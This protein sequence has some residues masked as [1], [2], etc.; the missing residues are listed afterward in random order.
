MVQAQKAASAVFNLR[1]G[2]TFL[3]GCLSGGLVIGA[4]FVVTNLGTG[5]NPSD[6]S[7]GNQDRNNTSNMESVEET[8]SGSISDQSIASMNLT[9]LIGLNPIAR[10]SKL[11]VFMSDANEGDFDDLLAQSEDLQPLELGAEFQNIIVG[12][13]AIVNPERAIQAVNGLE[14]EYLRK[15][16]LIKSIFNVWGVSDLDQAIQYAKKQDSSF[17]G[18]AAEGIITARDEL[19]VNERHDIALQ[20][21]GEESLDWTL[22]AIDLRRPIDNPEKTWNE[23]LEENRHKIGQ[24]DVFNTGYLGRVAHAIAGEIG[25]EAAMSKIDSALPDG[26]TKSSVYRWFFHSLSAEEPYQALEL[27][28]GLNDARNSSAITGLLAQNVAA[29]DPEGAVRIVSTIKA[30]GL[31]NTAIRRIINTWIESDP[32]GV[33]ANLE[34]LPENQRTKARV[35]ALVAIAADSTDAATRMLPDV[36]H[37]ESKVMVAESIFSNLAKN[38]MEAA[39]TW[40][41][42]DPNVAP[43]KTELMP[44]VIADLA[45]KDPQY[46]MQ[47]AHSVAIEESEVGLE[48]QVIKSVA[49]T[50][51]DKA[52][53]MLPDIRNEKT[54]A[55]A[56][57]E[58][59]TILVRDGDAERAIEIGGQITDEKERTRYFA[60]LIPDMIVEAPTVFID[61]LESFPT[62]RET[63]LRVRAMM[64]LPIFSN[65]FS[66]EQQDKIRERFPTPI[67]EGL[68]GLFDQI[69]IPARLFDGLRG[70]TSD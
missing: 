56:L 38:D 3:V 57:A 20:L 14:S 58:I 7:T 22:G 50:N 18:F 69:Q 64:V 8:K 15:A 5:G 30:S 63:A 19:S 52:I 34:L 33:M 16:E 12:Q 32:Y 11:R 31:R 44:S 36:N 61:N 54:M 49:E 27:A 10:M 65:E 35:D 6:R 24:L 21:V 41:L 9:D 2:L 40:L 25:L 23:F 26:S 55:S 48:A 43:I 51:V 28:I 39:V 4:V 42:S 13:F 46:A 60:T 59:G 29:V 37:Y 45:T 70:R 66:A 53:A 17:R 62:N 67:G 68:E 47:I 1:T